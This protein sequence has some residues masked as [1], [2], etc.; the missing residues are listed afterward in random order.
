VKEKKREAG[1]LERENG[2]SDPRTLEFFPLSSLHAFLPSTWLLE[3][4]AEERG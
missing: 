1:A 3:A 2:S 4:S